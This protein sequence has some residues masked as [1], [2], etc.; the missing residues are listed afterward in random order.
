MTWRLQEREPPIH[1]HDTKFTR[2]FDIVFEA[3]GVE[4]VDIP[5]Q[6]PNANAF[7]ERWVR[8]VREECLDKLIIPDH[9]AGQP[10]T[11]PVRSPEDGLRCR[12]CG[13]CFTQR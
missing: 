9:L 2:V 3:E 1:D 6:A 10:Y 12:R 8:S 7:A 11:T 5:Y 4:I 13:W